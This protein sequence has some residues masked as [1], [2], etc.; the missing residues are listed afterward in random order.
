MA[1]TYTLSV[2]D[3]IVLNSSG[4]DLTMTVWRIESPGSSGRAESAG[5]RVMAQIR[6]GGYGIGF[7]DRSGQTWR[8]ATDEEEQAYRA[9]EAA[10]GNS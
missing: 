6:P 7:D 1:S 4:K 3:V 9:K 2:G 5:P 8:K 10:R